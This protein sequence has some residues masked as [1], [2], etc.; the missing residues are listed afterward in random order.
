MVGNRPPKREVRVLRNEGPLAAVKWVLLNPDISTTVPYAKNIA[1]VQMNSGQCRILILLRTRKCC[2]R[3]TRRSVRSTV[4]CAMSA[5][6]NARTGYGSLIN[7]GTLPKND[8]AGDFSQARDNFL[9]LPKEIRSSSLQRSPF[10]A[11]QCQMGLKSKQTNQGARSSG[12]ASQ[13]GDC[14]IWPQSQSYQL[15]ERIAFQPLNA[16]RRFIPYAQESIMTDQLLE[17]MRSWRG[18]IKE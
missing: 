2:L 11:I 12:I 9:S 4:V 15:P 1:E 16:I 17:R 3:E 14:G 18:R 6:A 13:I 8:F 5:K 10:A 7:R